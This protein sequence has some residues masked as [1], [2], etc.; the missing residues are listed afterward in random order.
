VKLDDLIGGLKAAGEPTRLRLLVVLSRAELTVSELTR[1]LGQSQ[2][3]ISRHL[4]LLCEA[5]LLDR[6]REG[7]WVFYRLM[8]PVDG[9]QSLAT[10]ILEF[11]ETHD[12]ALIRDLER[13]ELVREARREEAASY[14]A[15]AADEWEE[16]RSLHV[17]E[18][19]VEKAMLEFVGEGRV[20]TYL[21]IGTGTGR[22]LEIFGPKAERGVGIDLSHEMLAIAR[23]KIE[24]AG[25]SHC[26]I[27]HGDLFALDVINGSTGSNG[28]GEPAD[29]ITLHQVLHYL[30]DPALAVKEAVRALKPGGQLLIA[31]FAP[32]AVEHLRQEHSHRRLGFS[33]EE[34]SGWCMRAGLDDIKIKHL[35]P[36]EE[37]GKTLTVTLWAAVKKGEQMKETYS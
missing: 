29:L 24:E 8:R 22:M 17:P 30:P 12:P 20:A 14:F 7:A 3:R 28:I 31:D 35:P 36:P 4:K 37:E 13:L 2:P 1:V 5:Q 27:R 33:D 32:H 26:Q 16:L 9:E 23:T 6:F 34:V 10:N 25:L 18:N 15:K 19:D 21:D 11:V